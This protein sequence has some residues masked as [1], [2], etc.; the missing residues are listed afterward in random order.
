[1]RLFTQPDAIEKVTNIVRAFDR[2]AEAFRRREFQA[3][4]KL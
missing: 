3:L 2:D 1:M 4:S